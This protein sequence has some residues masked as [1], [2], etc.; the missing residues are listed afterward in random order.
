MSEP[1]HSPIGTLEL[2]A[3]AEGFDIDDKDVESIETDK[4]G[5]IISAVV[6][7]V[8]ATLVA[9]ASAMTWAIFFNMP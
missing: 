5:W 7:L 8:A 6:A 9:A 4:V 1:L 3:A 2:D